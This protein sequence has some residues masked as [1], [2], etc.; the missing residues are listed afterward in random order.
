M[1]THANDGDKSKDDP[2]LLTQLAK[3]GDKQAFERLYEMYFAPVFRYIYFR[4]KN[5]EEAEDMSQ[6]VF[7]KAFQAL[8]RFEP[9]QDKSP[10]AYFFTVARNTVTDYWRKKNAVAARETSADALVFEPPDETAKD[11]TGQIENAHIIRQALRSLTEEQQEVIILRFIN[12]LSCKEVARL[13]G[14]S[15]AAVRQLQSRAL[16]ALRKK[17]PPTGR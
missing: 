5:K 15:S 2:L 16:A 1:V 14:K 6:T 8:P 7:L 17:L 10:L 11:V 4:V 9:Q 3:V 12:D 13:L